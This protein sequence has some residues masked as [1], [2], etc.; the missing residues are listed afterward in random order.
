MTNKEDQIK[1]FF[2]KIHNVV[3][4]FNIIITEEDYLQLYIKQMYD[5]TIVDKEEMTKWENK[6]K[7]KNMWVNANT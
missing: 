7:A 5:N 6:T 1:V 3:A 2:K 4:D